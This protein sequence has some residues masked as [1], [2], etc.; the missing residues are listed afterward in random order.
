MKPKLHSPQNTSSQILFPTLSVML[1]CRKLQSHSGHSSAC[2]WFR[3]GGHGC[4]YYQWTRST[5]HDSPGFKW[6][7][8]QS[9]FSKWV[10]KKRKKNA[11]F[12]QP[13]VAS[14][15][16]LV[17]VSVQISQSKIHKKSWEKSICFIKL[18]SK[19]LTAAA[20][21]LNINN[22]NG[23]LLLYNNVKHHSCQSWLNTWLSLPHQC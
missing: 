22:R 15:N 19:S 5:E 11:N 4:I 21:P 20:L 8:P 13:A 16:R 17:N 18:I 23:N 3:W 10:Q 12:I 6:P 9:W 14:V 1:T 2:V 7:R